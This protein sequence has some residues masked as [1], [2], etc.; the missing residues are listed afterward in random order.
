MNQG[1]KA[2]LILFNTKGNMIFI[3]KFESE[4]KGIEYMDFIEKK[5]YHFAYWRFTSWEGME[6]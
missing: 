2:K 4:K 6:R 1:Y 3:M 5:K